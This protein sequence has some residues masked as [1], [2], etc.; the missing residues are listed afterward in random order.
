ME[1]AWFITKMRVMSLTSRPV[2]LS[3]KR[4]VGGLLSYDGVGGLL[5]YDVLL[6]DLGG[7]NNPSPHLF[8]LSH[9][10]RHAA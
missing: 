7:L 9:D 2:V 6:D 8:C 4:R 1:T 10:R 5:S 3:L